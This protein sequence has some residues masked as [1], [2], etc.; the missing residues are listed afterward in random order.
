MA[1]PEHVP[2]M[3]GFDTLTVSL[4]RGGLVLA[5]TAL[6][7]MAAVEAA[8]AGWFPLTAWSLAAGVALSCANLHLYDKRIRWIIA[9]FGW[10]GLV[11]LGFGTLLQV[12]VLSA[13]GLGFSFAALSGLALKEQF[14]FRV[15]GLRLV[16][17]FL[18]GSLIP[19]LT[20]PWYLAAALHGVAAIVLGVLVFAK[21]A[22]P[23][24]FDVGDRSRYQ[25]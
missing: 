17:L 24:H 13:A 18:A 2:H 21:M 14:C 8:N 3:D 11:V 5:V 12:R 23:A 20:G 22:Q 7:A 1:N 6:V 16:P 4:Y 19:V 10:T 15:P 9:G 25:V